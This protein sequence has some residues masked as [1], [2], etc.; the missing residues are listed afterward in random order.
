MSDVLTLLNDYA[1]GGA[2]VDAGLISRVESHIERLEQR[3]AA[4]ET[5]LREELQYPYAEVPV[6]WAD[7]AREI[8][9]DVKKTCPCCDGQGDIQLHDEGGNGAYW[10]CTACNGKGEVPG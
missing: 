3:L 10:Q 5:L 2:V 1:S 4:A 6:G 8:V 7:R 9:G